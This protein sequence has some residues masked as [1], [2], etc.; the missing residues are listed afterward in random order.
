MFLNWSKFGV[1]RIF[2]ILYSWRTAICCWRFNGSRRRI[3]CDERF[4]LFICF[5]FDHNAE[6][7]NFIFF[8]HRVASTE[9]WWRRSRWPTWWWATTTA[10]AW[11]SLTASFFCISGNRELFCFNLKFVMSFK[12]VCFGFSLIHFYYYFLINILYINLNQL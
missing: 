3:F 6:I 4:W 12:F 8:L 10:R 2:L 1:S 11:V 9:S 7:D 5:F